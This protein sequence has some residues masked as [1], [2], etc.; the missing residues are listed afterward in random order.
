MMT[1]AALPEA[2]GCEPP[3]S[4]ATGTGDA[5][6]PDMGVCDA[7]RASGVARRITAGESMAVSANRY[8]DRS[9]SMSPIC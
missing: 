3:S 8:A 2:G 6:V 4:T 5:G 9:R 7:S 1:G